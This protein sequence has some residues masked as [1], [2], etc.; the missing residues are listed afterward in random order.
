MARASISYHTS[1][2]DL[3]ARR[4]FATKIPAF[5]MKHPFLPIL[6]SAL[7]TA[8][9]LPLNYFLAPQLH[10]S[11]SENPAINRMA[12]A[13]ICTLALVALVLWAVRRL[14][15][16]GF[17]KYW[18]LGDAA[19]PAEKVAW[20][21]IRENESWRSVGAGF[22]LVVTAATAA[23]MWLGVYQKTPIVWLDLLPW[24]LLFSLSNSFSEEMLTRFTLAA[25][26]D[27]V[28][29]KAQIC[30]WSAAIFGGVHFFGTPGGIM[31][32]LMAGFLGW[33]LAK[34]VVETRGFGWAW[35]IHFLQDVVII[36]A[37]LHVE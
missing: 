5:H 29:S 7:G 35:F 11:F 34:S 37:L 28:Q 32:V 9:L 13:Q 30:L 15:P 8:A 16:E 4:N 25:G 36:F 31:G 19:A 14:H 26:L 20:L 27:G 3:P 6:L 24:V 17:R 2:F 21:G 10:L 1:M 12:A 33:L 22:S 18:W 23:F